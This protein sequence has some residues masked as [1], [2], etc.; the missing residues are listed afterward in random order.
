MNDLPT[1]VNSEFINSTMNADDR[2][3]QI[4]CK[5]F[6]LVKDLVNNF[7]S[8]INYGF[9]VTYFACSLIIPKLRI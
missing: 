9:A 1:M 3:V 5:S 6:A 7:N 4:S 8:V 2:V